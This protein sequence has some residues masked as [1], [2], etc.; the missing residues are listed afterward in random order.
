[1]NYFLLLKNELSLA[2]LRKF[3]NVVAT[4]KSAI[5]LY[6]ARDETTRAE[7]EKQEMQ[8]LEKIIKTQS[9]KE[10]PSAQIQD[11]AEEETKGESVTGTP[12]TNQNDKPQ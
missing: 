5:K 9:S 1:M 2:F 4:I 12:N 7:I 11:R 6:A 3:D 10:I 8:A